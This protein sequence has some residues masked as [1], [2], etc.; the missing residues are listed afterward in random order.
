MKCKITWHLQAGNGCR[1]E[2]N[3][4]MGGGESDFV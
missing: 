2:V 3:R 1:K 4:R